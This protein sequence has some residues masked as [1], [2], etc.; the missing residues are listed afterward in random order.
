MK[1]MFYRTGEK[2]SFFKLDCSNWNVEKVTVHDDFNYGVS[3]KVIEPN[4]VN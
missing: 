1:N 4:W 2:S 3:S